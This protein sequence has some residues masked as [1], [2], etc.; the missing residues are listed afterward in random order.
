[1]PGQFDRRTVSYPNPTTSRASRANPAHS[2]QNGGRA[3]GELGMG[4]GP[5]SR[6]EKAHPVDRVGFATTFT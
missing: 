3:T 5:V 4:I 1:M 2:H 6:N